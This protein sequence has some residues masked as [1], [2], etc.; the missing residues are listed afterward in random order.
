MMQAVA[1]AFLKSPAGPPSTRAKTTRRRGQEYGRQGAQGQRDSAGPGRPTSWRTFLRAH[2][3]ASR[4]RL[5]SLRG[6]DPSRAV[7]YYTNFVIDLRSRRVHVAGSTPTPDA[8]FMAQ[9]ARRLIDAVD[10]FLAGHRILI[11][12]RDAKWTDG[13]RRIV[14]GS[15][16]RVVL[17]PAQAAECQRLR[18]T[19]RPLQPRGMSRRRPAPLPRRPRPKGRG[20][21]RSQDESRDRRAEDR[22][23]GRV[24]GGCSPEARLGGW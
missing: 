16:I 1:H 9:A 11:C 22:G 17:T 3:G 12:D 2:W 7:P 24:G 10:G 19:V 5:L 6:L 15:G 20:R 4:G 13:F 18:G 23:P 14:E 8:W 21:A